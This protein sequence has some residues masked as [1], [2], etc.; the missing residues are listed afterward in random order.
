MRDIQIMGQVLPA[1]ERL[2]QED[3]LEKPG[4]EYLLLAALGL[5]DDSGRAAFRAVGAEPTAYHDAIRSVHAEALGSLGI[6]ASTLDSDIPDV[7]S[8][9]TGVFKAEPSLH[10]AF[11][12][13]SEKVRSEKS[14]L[15]GAYFVETICEAEFG[16]AVRAVEAMDID[17]TLLAAA[18]REQIEALNA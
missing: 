3:G 5:D 15:Y 7:P 4:A 12:T 6:D 13:V 9:P 10:D 8:T 17:P 14:Q 1:A 18:A 11:Q 16:T 2:A